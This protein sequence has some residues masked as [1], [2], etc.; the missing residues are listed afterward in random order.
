MRFCRTSIDCC[1][2][3]LHRACPVTSAAHR[4][5]VGAELRRIREALDL[6]GVAVGAAL[7]WSQSKVSRIE[8]ARFGATLSELA[9]LLDYY[10]VPEEVRAELLAVAAEGDGL[11]G[12]WIVRA[13][14]PKRRQDEVA[15]IESRVSRIRYYATITVPGILQTP[16]YTRAITSAGGFG[17]PE[18]L[19][20][21]RQNRQTLL[22]KEDAPKYALVLDQR[23]LSRWAGGNHV[24]TAQLAKLADAAAWP[25]V[26]L[27][28]M[29][30]G[31]N[32]AAIALAQFL[33]YDFR[34][35]T[36]PTVVQLESQTADVYLSGDSD[37]KVYAEL[38]DR[39]QAEAM[40]PEA[41]VT[42]LR[43]Q[44]R[45]LRRSARSD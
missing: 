29:P 4:A 40:E 23:A 37:I 39:L 19:L 41:S 43:S 6:S 13:G 26:R 22:A 14:G 27:Q 30:P 25:N 10:G 32:A 17:A 33:M 44:A 1:Y 5:R 36:S 9:A 31:G 3:V 8:T 20:A 21:S 42:Y 7:G 12:A 16:E 11:P 45:K 15:A 35:R 18:A 24:M 38:F 2:A 34:D 28:V